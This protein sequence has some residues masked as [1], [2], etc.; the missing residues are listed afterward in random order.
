ML[1]TYSDLIFQDGRLNT[2]INQIALCNISMS[3]ESWKET[4]VISDKLEEA[5]KAVRQL[6]EYIE[7][8]KEVKESQSKDVEIPPNKPKLNKLTK[9]EKENEV[10]AEFESDGNDKIVD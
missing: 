2:K 8:V 10:I 7:K 1:Q 4:K 6:K 9:E 3:Y 5:E